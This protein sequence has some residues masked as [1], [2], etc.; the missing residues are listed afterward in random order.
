MT[1][2]D[3]QWPTKPDGYFGIANPMLFEYYRALASAW[4]SVAR[5][6]GQHKRWCIY[7]KLLEH[8]NQ[9]TECDCGYSAALAG[10]PDRKER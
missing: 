4:E 8:G 1:S 2:R 3:K 5:E 6:W 10:V 7:W 9:P